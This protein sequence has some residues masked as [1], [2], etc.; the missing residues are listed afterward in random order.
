M[1]LL[2]QQQ[3]PLAQYMLAFEYYY[4]GDWKN[5]NSVLN[6]MSTNLHFSTAE[7]KQ[8]QDYLQY[9]SF[10]KLLSDNGRTIYTL[11]S[12]DINSLDSLIGQTSEPVK[13]YAQNILESNNLLKY[14]E[15]IILPEDLKSAPD[16]KS[17]KTMP[18]SK[19]DW[20]HIFPNPARQ[21]IIVEYNLADK[22][23]TQQARIVFSVST[24]DGK[25][26]ETRLLSKPQDQF[27]VNTTNYSPGIFLFT[28]QLSGKTVSTKKVT[29]TN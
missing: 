3:N 28:I 7:T 18:F 16:K 21:Y 11:T 25:S 24:L 29:I 19:N 1:N 8:Y 5:V 23:S 14:F 4:L 27:L 12:S 26:I 9:F 13:S 22:I 20:L 2:A 6:N 10:L 15:P 17:I